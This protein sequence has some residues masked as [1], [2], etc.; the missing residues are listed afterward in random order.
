MV[1][2]EK[3]GRLARDV[4]FPIAVAVYLLVRF[5]LLLREN[6]AALWAVK[7]AVDALAVSVRR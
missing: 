4:G 2:V 7:V 1:D 6:T 3:Y 5:D